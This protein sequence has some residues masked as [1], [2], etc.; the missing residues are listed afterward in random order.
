MRVEITLNKAYAARSKT[1]EVCDPESCPEIG[2]IAQHKKKN[3]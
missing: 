3:V 1:S 2:D